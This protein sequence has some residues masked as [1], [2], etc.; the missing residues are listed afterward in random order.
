MRS[1]LTDWPK[2]GHFCFQNIF[3]QSCVIGIGM[4]E[5]VWSDGLK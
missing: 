4:P 5:K 2:K 1:T 3:K